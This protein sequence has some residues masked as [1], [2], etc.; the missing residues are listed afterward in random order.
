VTAEHRWFVRIDPGWASHDIRFYGDRWCKTDLSTVTEN[1][2]GGKRLT[3][4]RLRPAPTLF[5]KAVWIAL[6]Y[7]LALAWGIY[8]PAVAVLSPLVA[9]PLLWMWL[10]GRRLNE[11]VMASV[12]LVARRQGMSVVGEPEGLDALDQADESTLPAPAT[13]AARLATAMAISPLVRRAAGLGLVREP[14]R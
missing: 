14:H 7:L 11:V 3:R 13:G 9:G 5:Q 12:L 2:G 8:A 6:G 1:H 10:S 4:V